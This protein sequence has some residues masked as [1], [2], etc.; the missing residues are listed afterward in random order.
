MQSLS[1][2]D[3][4]QS[5]ILN[6]HNVRLRSALQSLSTESTT[7]MA[8]DQ[9]ARLHGNFAQIAGIEASLTL[10]NAYR[11]VGAET[12]NKAN[13]MQ[14]ALKTVQDQAAALGADLLT[15]QTGR[16]SAQI[17]ILG[18]QAAQGLDLA[19]KALNTSLGESALFS[20]QKTATIALAGSD[21]LLG[22]LSTAISAA[23]ATSASDIQDVVTAWFG[24]PAG[25]SA[26]IYQGG[27]PLD[28]VCVSADQTVQL[29]ITA[30]DPAIVD[31]LKAL[32]LGALLS[33]G[34]LAGSAVARADLAQRAGQQLVAAQ[35]PMTAL[36]ARLGTLQASL[37]DATTRN[38]AEDSA[39]QNA[40]LSL[41]S[42]DPYETATKM[43][44]VQTQLQ[45]L[46]AIT[47]R[48]SRLSLVDF[49]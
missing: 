36:S 29:D 17:D 15:A 20:G 3:L 33:R 38:D 8:A 23:Q 34:I 28:P 1:L 39:L 30:A 16:S 13:M 14:E 43:Q 31:T 10:L 5:L 24:S 26:M 9:S 18:A 6:R 7:G 27:S 2:G 19:M 25:F 35:V 22:A 42:V 4:S 21:Q 45:T 12:Q 48:V 41:L 46:Y 49:L 32:S 11:N 47:A 37:Q 44:D 40:R